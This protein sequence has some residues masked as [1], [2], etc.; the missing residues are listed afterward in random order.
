LKVVEAF[1]QGLGMTYGI[2]K[3]AALRQPTEKPM[4]RHGLEKKHNVHVYQMITRCI[5]PS[6]RTLFKP[7]KK[8]R[9]QHFCCP[10]HRTVFFTLARR[11]GAALLIK[12]LSDPK[13]ES[14]VEDLLIDEKKG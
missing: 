5:L 8:G 11:V 14:I 9:K 13:L 4:V 3:T 1:D 12:S 10:D 7:R 6:C 2:L